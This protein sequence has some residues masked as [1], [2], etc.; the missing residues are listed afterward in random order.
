MVNVFSVVISLLGL[1]PTK[2]DDGL[3]CVLQ[4]LSQNTAADYSGASPVREAINRLKAAS[5]DTSYCG[6]QWMPFLES[7]AQMRGQ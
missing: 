2:D 6:K 5:L 7:A 3:F 4:A 1:T